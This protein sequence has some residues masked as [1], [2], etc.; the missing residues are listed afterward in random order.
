[1]QGDLNVLYVIQT[2]QL[3][4]KLITTNKCT[5]YVH[6]LVVIN[7]KDLNMSDRFP[8]R[9]PDCLCT[10][11]QVKI[12]AHVKFCVT[13]HQRFHV[14]FYTLCFFIHKSYSIIQSLFVSYSLVHCINFSKPNR[15]RYYAYRQVQHQKTSAF[16]PHNV[17]IH[18]IR[19]LQ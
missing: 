4:I 18:S 10:K 14:P 17:S 1:M 16:C 6:L 19:F 12:H 8:F 15:P 5:R 7:C 3:V 11:S 13:G 2:V 9:K